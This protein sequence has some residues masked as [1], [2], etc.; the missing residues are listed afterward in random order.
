MYTNAQTY[1]NPMP[2]GQ[3]VNMA[4]NLRVQQK[5]LIE[6]RLK[7]NYPKKFIIVYSLI[8]TLISIAEIVL[9]VLLII[10]K[11]AF[12]GIYHGIWGGCLMLVIP[13]LSLLLSIFI[14]QNFF[15]FFK[16]F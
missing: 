6:K 10:Y 2:Y 16:F 4:Q 11:G 1:D 3:Q 9:H 13:L 7:E 14:T 5:E 12:Y 15:K 8:I